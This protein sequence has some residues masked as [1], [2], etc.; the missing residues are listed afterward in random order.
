MELAA[1]WD[2]WLRARDVAPGERIACALPPGRAF[3][4]LLIAALGHGVTLALLPAGAELEDASATLDA[5]LVI[6]A[7][8]ADGGPPAITEPRAVRGA[9]TPTVRF[10]LQ[11]TGTTGAARWIALS[12]ANVRA[13]LDSHAPAHPLAGA[14]VVSVLPWHHAFGLSI[15]LL[16]ALLAGATLVREPSAG[17]DAAS[18]LAACDAHGVTH[19]DAVP[20]TLRVLATH[21]GG[22]AL[23]RR[24]RG[25]VVGGAPVDARLAELLAHTR[26]RVGYGQTEASPGIALGAPGEWRPGLLGRPLG[27]DVRVDDDGVLAFRGPNACVGSWS[28]GALSVFPD[29]RW[30]RTGDLV[31]Q[32]P[33]GTL[34][35]EGRV[36][37][38]FKLANG[39]YVAAAAIESEVLTRFSGVQEA[40]L[41][42]PDGEALVLAFSGVTTDVSI[43]TVRPLLGG[44]ATR[45]LRLVRVAP[46]DWQ[47]TP[48]GELDR[49]HPTGRART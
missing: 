48:K 15:Q 12:D 26:L 34:L 27:C 43:E 22:A 2:A 33:D 37:G 19:L 8:R 3:A 36:A 49:R 14:T 30:V 29:A 40:L 47:R 9:S 1:T 20:H 16:P 6:R 46:D 45:P 17:R 13:V 25:G 38:S 39:R 18:L 32:E 42:S 23:L 5:R 31:R 24:L 21:A 28:E 44:L 11:T 10:L 7:A 35:F 4:A 41:S